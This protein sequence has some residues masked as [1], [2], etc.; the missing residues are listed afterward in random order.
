MVHD[1]VHTA[2]K[3]SQER[4]APRCQRQQ[5]RV[6]WGQGEDQVDVHR[7][8]PQVARRGPLGLTRGGD[9]TEVPKAQPRE[10]VATVV[11]MV[12]ATTRS[13]KCWDEVS[14]QCRVVGKRGAKTERWGGT[15]STI[16]RSGRP[17]S[18]GSDDDDGDGKH[19]W[20]KV[21]LTSI[22]SPAGR[23]QG[24]V[25]SGS[26]MAATCLAMYWSCFSI[27]STVRSA[28]RVERSR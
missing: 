28:T 17:H 25:L 23:S 21:G 18:G 12:I 5:R 7:L 8:V 26:G 24:R 20:D 3:L 6:R 2:D 4:Q 16:P 11:A 15:H 14:C 22:S 13:T 9:I 1:L 19:D 27:R 10:V